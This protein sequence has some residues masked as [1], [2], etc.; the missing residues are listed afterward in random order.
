MEQAAQE[1]K[2]EDIIDPD[3]VGLLGHSA[4]ANSTTAKGEN[5]ERYDALVPMAGGGAVS[6]DVPVLRIDASCDGFVPSAD[7]TVLDTMTDGRFVQV[8]GGGHLAFTDL[9]ALD[10]GTLAD[11]IIA[12]R[13]DANSALLPQLRRLAVDGCPGE[14]PLVEAPECADAF[15][16]LEVSDSIVRYHLT[17][18]FDV[19]LKGAPDVASQ[20]PYQDATFWSE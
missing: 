1:A 10:L 4:G 20:N 18:F 8:H 2:W 6:R 12:P 3:R 7:E 9:C 15:L 14:T 13:E 5:D 19:V 16:P 17:N 11:D